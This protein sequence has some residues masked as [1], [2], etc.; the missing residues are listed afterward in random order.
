MSLVA[1]IPSRNKISISV[2]L[3]FSIS[4]FFKKHPSIVYFVGLANIWRLAC[5]RGH[6]SKS[7]FARICL[8]SSSSADAVFLHC[9]WMIW[10]NRN[11]S[12]RTLIEADGK[13]LSS[14]THGVI[15]LRG[16][17]KRNLVKDL[18]SFPDSF[19]FLSNEE[20]P[21]DDWPTIWNPSRFSGLS[22]LFL[23]PSTCNNR[24][25]GHDV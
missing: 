5:I 17:N 3:S 23:G 18:A 15:T 8:K 16:V 19:D 12:F 2:C 6:S 20:R 7:P 1:Y 10:I 11:N 14:R 9:N 24:C 4:L 13:R 25:N 21:V 22:C